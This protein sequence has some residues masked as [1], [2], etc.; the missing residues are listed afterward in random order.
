MQRRRDLKPCL[1]GSK[2]ISFQ[3]DLCPAEFIQTFN[4]VIAEPVEHSD[5]IVRTDKSH[6]TIQ[7]FFGIILCYRIDRFNERARSSASRE[8]YHSVLERIIH[9]AVQL[10]SQKVMPSFRVA[11]LIGSVLPDFADKQLLFAYRLDGD[12][13]L[14]NEFFGKLV[15]YVQSPRADAQSRPFVYDTVFAENEIAV[16]FCLLINRRTY[17]D[18]P[19][20]T[21]FVGIVYKIV[22]LIIRRLLRLIRS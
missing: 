16:T 5:R 2:D 1:S 19:P 9:N 15:H 11:Y 7:R 3:H 8:T 4:V 20:A 10:F 17:G 12:P 6:R 18:P 22:P 14:L 21:V 13:D